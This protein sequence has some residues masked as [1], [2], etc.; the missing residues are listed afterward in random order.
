MTRNDYYSKLLY[1]VV[2]G[3]VIVANILTGLVF[4]G[5]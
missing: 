5:Q 4:L 2:F 3:S 1:G